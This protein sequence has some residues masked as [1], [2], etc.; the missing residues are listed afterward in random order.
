MVAF[1]TEP[2]SRYSEIRAPTHRTATAPSLMLSASAYSFRMKSR[3]AISLSWVAGYVNV[4]VFLVCGVVTSHTTGNVTHSGLLAVKNDFWPAIFSGFLVLAF[5]GGAVASAFMVEGAK[6]RG[7]RS[8]YILPMA[9]QALLLCA[10]ALLIDYFELHHA[11]ETGLAKGWGLYCI[12]GISSFSMGLQNA[13]VTTV[14]GAVVR[15]THLTGVVTDLGLEGVQYFLWALDRTRGR[16]GRVGRVWR[17][18]QRHPSLLRLALL[19]SIFGSFLFGV[20]AGTFAFVRWPYYAMV[21]PVS[22]LVWIIY[23]DWRKPIADVT[24]LDLLRDAEITSTLGDVKSWLPPEVGIYRLTH[25]QKHS[26]HHAPDF[27]L[28]VDRLPEHWRVIILAVSPLTHFDKEEALNLQAAAQKLRSRERDLIICGISRAQFKVLSAAGLPDALGME[29]FCPDLELALARGIN[30][31]V[32][33]TQS[34]GES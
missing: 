24:E 4:I 21:V 33:L 28:W 9:V 2:R 25:H 10:L 1:A 15:T 22:F 16:A 26:M 31:L 17:L 6:R 27:Q 20:V 18:S 8:K 29:N 7:A 5:L 30:R 3:L 11:W 14:S 23:V 34:R 13:T 12:A 32:E 19:A